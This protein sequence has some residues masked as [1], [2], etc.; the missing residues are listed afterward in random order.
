MGFGNGMGIGWANAQNGPTSLGAFISPSN[1]L[2]IEPGDYTLRWWMGNIVSTGGDPQ[3]V[4]S[5]GDTLDTHSAFIVD[6]SSSDF[7]FVYTINGIII[8]DVYISATMGSNHWNFFCIE[9]QADKVYFS[10]N[11]VWLASQ[12]TNNNPVLAYNQPLYIGSAN[13]QY[14]LNAQL[15]N[16]EWVTQLAIYN[17]SIDFAPPTQNFAASPFY[18]IFLLFI[19]NN[20]AE[21]LHDNGVRGLNATKGTLTTYY[22]DNPWG[23]LTTGCGQF[24]I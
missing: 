21:I 19:G 18:T 22:Q 1:N 13:A 14:P 20:L 4:F 7:N 9:R 3:T 2:N 6:T 23:N 10:V 8:I 16:F 11:G 24:Y 12:T 5:I 17:P 15:C